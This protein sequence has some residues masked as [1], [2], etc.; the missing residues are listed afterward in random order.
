MTDIPTASRP[1]DSVSSVETV[2]G[3]A[4]AGKR[5]KV[6]TACRNCRERKTRCDGRQPVCIACERRQVGDTCSYE[7]SHLSSKQ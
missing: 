4:R 1:N 3:N 2:T 6:G 7:R 5:S